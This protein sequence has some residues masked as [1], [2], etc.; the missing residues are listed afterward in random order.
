[1]LLVHP[2]RWEL[3][4]WFQGTASAEA[5]RRRQRATLR[6]NE[7]WRWGSWNFFLGLALSS[8]TSSV[9]VSCPR[10]LQHPMKTQSCADKRSS[11]PG[12]FT[13]RHG[14]K[15]HCCFLCFCCWFLVLCPLPTHGPVIIIIIRITAFTPKVYG[16]ENENTI[17]KSLWPTTTKFQLWSPPSNFPFFVWLVVLGGLYVLHSF[18]L[19]FACSWFVCHVYKDTYL[20]RYPFLV[21]IVTYCELHNV[22][23]LMWSNQEGN[24][25]NHDHFPPT[26]A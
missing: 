7:F 16:Q 12:F 19:A 8:S 24:N 26:L 2:R 1:M 15:I 18:P 3:W 5:R 20:V 14:P 13:K 22:P 21:I 17:M 11:H 6:M 9:V 10:T 25:N 4:W 23:G